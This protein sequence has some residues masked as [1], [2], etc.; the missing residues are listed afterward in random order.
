MLLSTRYKLPVIRVRECSQRI[1]G[2]KD[3]GDLGKKKHLPSGKC[4]K[5]SGLRQ[6]GSASLNDLPAG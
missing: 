3:D 5:Q 2:L 6:Q 1:C 4:I